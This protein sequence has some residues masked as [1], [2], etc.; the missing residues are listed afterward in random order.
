MPDTGDHRCLVVDDEAGLRSVLVRTLESAGY[1]CEQAGS[2]TEALALLERGTFALV[3]SDIRMP[4]MD[5]VGLLRA[6]QQRWPDTAVVMLTAVAEVETAVACLRTGAFDY[7]AKPFQVDEVLARVAQALEKRQLVLD[8]RQYQLHLAD[9]VRQQAVRIEELFLE[10]VQTLVHALE[11]KDPYT[12]GH[13][14]RVAAYAGA[15]GRALGLPEP[16]LQVL[17]LGAELHDIGKIGVRESVLRKEGR[18]TRDEYEHI[19]SHT[20]I[21]AR[22]L[23]P[24]LKHEPQAIAIVRSHH[25]RLDGSG[26]PDGLRGEQIPLMARI[27]TVADSFDAMTSS[28][29]YR[30]ALP[31]E[32]ALTELLTRSG[33]QF[34]PAVV[35]AFNQAKAALNALPL[36]TPQ[37]VQRRVPTRL[38]AGSLASKP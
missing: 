10:G 17:E 31:V 35:A 14:A 9:M 18:L 16:D 4:G 7:I 19:M 1:P 29:P 25:E 28:R 22:I 30:P 20:V 12:Q 8:N 2:G 6:V 32:H 21:G 38:A 26:L 11:A 37:V 23:D 13:S 34:D 24:L 36:P 27:V 15:I 3:L 5:G 33:D